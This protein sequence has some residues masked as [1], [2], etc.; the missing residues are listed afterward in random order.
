MGWKGS[1]RR[2]IAVHRAELFPQQHVLSANRKA[3]PC[4]PSLDKGLRRKKEGRGD[5][6]GA[7]SS[8]GLGREQ[9]S[10]RVSGTACDWRKT[11]PWED[12]EQRSRMI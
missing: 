3:D 8:Q 7:L 5:Q 2:K 4:V 11:K 12:F 1:G 6:G 9:A 10:R